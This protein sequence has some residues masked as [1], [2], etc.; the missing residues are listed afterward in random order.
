MKGTNKGKRWAYI[1]GLIICAI[2]LGTQRALAMVTQVDKSKDGNF[3]SDIRQLTMAGARSGEA[4]YRQDGKY[5][6]FQSEREPGNPFYQIYL[7]DLEKGK[8]RRISTGRGKTTCAW[9]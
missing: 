7:M 9:V 5:L 8:N 1:G 6:A 2:G 3:L 4:Y